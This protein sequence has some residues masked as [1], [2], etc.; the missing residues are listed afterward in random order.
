MA[1]HSIQPLVEKRLQWLESIDFGVRLANR[2]G[3]LWS[4][5]PEVQQFCHDFTGWVDVAGRTLSIVPKIEALKTELLSEGFTDAVVLGMGGSSLSALMFAQ[6]FPQTTGLR[7]HVLDSTNP[8]DVAHLSSK[9]NLEQTVFIVASKSGSTIEPLAMEEYFFH[10]HPA[11]NPANFFVAI[12]DPNSEMEVRAVQRGYRA[13]FHGEPA[14][15][16]RF[17]VF[18]PFGIIPAALHG[19]PV[20]EMLNAVVAREPGKPESN[21]GLELGAWLTELNIA[22][23]DKISIVTTS[24]RAFGLWAEQLVAESTGKNQYGVLPIALEPLTEVNSLGPKR[25]FYVVGSN[26]EVTLLNSKLKPSPETH[27]LERSIKNEIELAELL[28]D[29]EIATAVVGAALQINP[30]D[31]PNVQQAKDIAKTKL[32]AIQDAGKSDLGPVTSQ[33]NHLQVIAG[34]ADSP[35][36]EIE[37]FLKALQP[38]DHFGILAFVPE[39]AAHLKTLQ[40]LRKHAAQFFQV[41][42]SLGFGPRYLHS[43][44]QFHKGGPNDQK[45]ILITSDIQQDLAIPGFNASFGQLVTAQ[46]LGDFGA[47][48][49]NCKP[50][51]HIHLTGDA[52]DGLNELLE[53][54][55]NR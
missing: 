33:S 9:L 40:E 18:S 20:R 6:D 14:V 45:F 32:K 16:G 7:L 54:I 51:V 8:A 26:N 21:P 23:I 4:T 31:Q 46:A 17:S 35:T 43:T 5:D 27:I 47:L 25:A 39:T 13:I 30:F 15:G 3:S 55:K 38:G 50:V 19:Y 53:I 52:V 22:G 37:S 2:D 10:N 42:T 36:E 41:A 49:Q 28:Y 1:N 29:W 48:Q 34:S 11:K 12:T 44:G 24:N